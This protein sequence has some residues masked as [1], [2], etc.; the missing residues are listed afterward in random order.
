VVNSLSINYAP[1]G[2]K[3]MSIFWGSRYVGSKL[4]TNDDVGGWSNLV[5]LDVRFDLGKSVDVSL[6]ASVREGNGARSFGDAVGPSLGIKP[7]D[8]GWISVGWNL[9][10]FHDRDFEQSRYT[11]AGPYVT[12]RVK[13]DQL[14]LAGLGIGRR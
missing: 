11:R 3:E 7:F 10:G 8:N 6:A 9:V 13:F 1:D 12:M 14:S 2:G 5:G 4:G